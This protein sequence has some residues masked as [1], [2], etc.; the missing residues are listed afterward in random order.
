MT[1]SVL[2]RKPVAIEDD[3][4]REGLHSISAA[5]PNLNQ[6]KEII[7]LV[8][9]TGVEHIIVGY[10][11]ASARAYEVTES[12]LKEIAE[13]GYA[14]RPWVLSRLNENDLS[15][16]EK[17][18]NQ[19][20]FKQ[21]RVA[22]FRAV[23]DIR[24]NI[25]K[26]SLKNLVREVS[27]FCLNF[28]SQFNF[29][30]NFED[31]TRASKSTLEALV[32]EANRLPIESVVLC[33]TVG[34]SRPNEVVD[35]VSDIRS[36][37]SSEIKLA[38]HGHNDLGLALAN[39]LAAVSSGVDIVSGTF[40]GI[41]ERAGNLALEQMMLNLNLFHQAQFDLS[42]VRELCTLL[43]KS[44][45][46]TISPWSPVV[47]DDIFSTQ[48]GIHAA[49]IIKGRKADCEAELIYNSYS[50]KTLGGDLVFRLGP[51]SGKKMILDYFKVLGIELKAHELLRFWDFV[52]L[53]D[54]VLE[55]EEIVAWI[56][57]ERETN[58]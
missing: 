48:A 28:S 39:S 4:L 45:G 41:G 51:L 20:Q 50:P 18:R 34:H 36:A 5:Q 42:R 38:W 32:A 24:L 22:G 26:S 3:T 23:S 56:N 9:Q 55:P 27:S 35:L 16:C 15:V 47:G 58:E 44:F 19:L 1:E 31:A 13:K 2:K 43:R 30:L 37:L 52:K 29:S 14:I 57:S 25:D 8:Q 17:L 53:K 7:A 46:V 49:A 40:L 12:L 21:L 6:L 54:R 33:D 11:A 10:P